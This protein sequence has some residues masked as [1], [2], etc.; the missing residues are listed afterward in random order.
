MQEQTVKYIWHTYGSRYA[1]G[2]GTQD[3]I[4]EPGATSIDLQPLLCLVP[5]STLPVLRWK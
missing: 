5:T 4:F 1:D 3:Q 2:S